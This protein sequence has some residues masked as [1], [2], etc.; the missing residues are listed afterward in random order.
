MKTKN[1]F[2]E[3][4]RD[5]IP[6]G[7][8][9]FAVA[10][11]LGLVA[12]NAGL[13][14]LQGFIASFTN[15]ASA[16]ENALFKAIQSSSKA[17]EIALITVVV[18]ARY[19]LMSCALS[20]RF[21]SDIPFCHRFLVGFGI[22]DEI[23]GISIA[24]GKKIEPLYNYG[25][26]AF[27][28]PMWSI[29]TSLGIIAGTYLPVRIVSA[30]SVALYGMFIAIIIPPAKRDPV[31][32][33]SVLSSFL[34]SYGFSVLPFVRNLSEGNRTII[35]TILIASVAAIVKPLPEESVESSEMENAENE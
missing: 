28:V 2:F 21:S 13:T 8:G 19:F 34:L 15:L 31:N 27:A 6:I 7:L 14:P 17:F 35:L 20:Q 33:V 4:F 9:Y 26:L 24:R 23:F 12:K 29:A 18:N 32:A 11:S 3:G 16:G 22:T 5:G 25:A 30:L 10:F 1:A